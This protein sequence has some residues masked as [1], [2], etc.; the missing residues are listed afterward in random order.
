MSKGIRMTPDRWR[1]IEDLYQRAL[2]IEENQRG[3]FLRD[4]CGGDDSLRR[5]VESLIFQTARD[6]FPSAPPVHRVSDPSITAATPHSPVRPPW[7]MFILASSFVLTFLLILYLVIWGSSEL[8][9]IVARFEGGAMVIGSVEPDSEAANGG[10]R[11]G[12]RDRR[13]RLEDRKRSE[14][15]GG[16]QE[17]V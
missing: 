16:H 11:A 12:D 15:Q 7:W 5:E 4:A 9:G 17:Y 6:G 2:D 1:Q 8:K 3:Q 14:Y 10:L 13:I